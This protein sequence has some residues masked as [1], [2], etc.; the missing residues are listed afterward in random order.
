MRLTRLVPI[1]VI[2]GVAALV[3]SVAARAQTTDPYV[4]TW[5]LDVAK[6]T[7]KPGPAPKST[8]VVVEAA[9]KGLKV[10]VDAVG[11]DGTPMKWGYTTMRDGKDAPVT[12]NP[13]YDAVALTQSTPT[14]ATAIYKKA[15]KVVIIEQVQRLGGRENA[16]PHQHR[17]G[18]QRA[19]RQQRV[20]VHEE[21][22]RGC[23][24]ANVA[25]WHLTS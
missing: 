17:N 21:V 15:G 11:A 9:G 8:T 2:T 14:T 5:T 10:S 3:F 12:G 20:R 7:Y 18:S 4:G 16:H 13:N 24:G 19:G 25:L 23:R 1:M 6:S 22:D